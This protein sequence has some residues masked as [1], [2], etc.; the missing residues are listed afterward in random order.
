MP[1]YSLVPVDYQPDFSDY[2]LVPVDY[3]PFGDDG[4]TQQAQAQPAQTQAQPAPPRPQSRPP[5]PTTGN[6]LPDVGPPLIGNGGQFSAGTAI[7]NKAADIAGKVAYGM[8][9]QVAT[10]PQRAMDAAAESFNHTYGPGPSTLSD[11]DVWVDPL[12]AVAAETALMTM[13]GIGAPRFAGI[14]AKS[15]A[16]EAGAALRNAAP[17]VAFVHARGDAIE[18]VGRSGSAESSANAPTG[19]SYSV[20]FETKLRPTSYPGLPRR[21]HYREA[22]EALLQAMEAND[23]FARNMQDLGVNLRRTPTGLAPLTPPT[24]FSWH[25]A[26]EPGV[27]QLVPRQQ[28]DPGTIFQDILHPDR[29]GGFFTWGK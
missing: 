24:G 19:N 25:H 8:M 14:G 27:L 17:E 9:R 20:L 4:A 28:H 21:A 13:G 26:E 3:D 16:E 22:N 7:G 2:S 1:D 12:P 11:S 6:D 10:L 18:G 23:A 5:Q 29:R 15:V